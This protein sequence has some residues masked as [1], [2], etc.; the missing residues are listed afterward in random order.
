MCSSQCQVPLSA[1]TGSVFLLRPAPVF[2][3]AAATA[4][5]EG[6]QIRHPDAK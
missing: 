5:N 1:S 6:H 3:V 2:W 4:Q